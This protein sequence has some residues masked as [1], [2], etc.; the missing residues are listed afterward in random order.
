VVVG[1]VQEAAVSV[2]GLEPFEGPQVLLGSDGAG[3]GVPGGQGGLGEGT[4]KACADAGD[5]A[6]AEDGGL[7]A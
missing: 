1:H 5:A 7:K 2:P 3:D 4:S 6:R